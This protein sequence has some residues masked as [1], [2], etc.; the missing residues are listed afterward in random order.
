MAEDKV[1]SPLLRRMAL[2]CLFVVAVVVV[3]G[4]YTRLVDAGLGCPDWPGCYGFVLVPQAPEDLQAAQARF[5]DA[6]IEAD[7]AWPE[8]VHRY[9][10]SGLGLLILITTVVAW[11]SRHQAPRVAG[12]TLAL[13][14]MVILQGAF[15]AW[16]VTLK[17][18]PQVVTAHLLGG[19]TTLS[20]IWLLCLRLGIGRRWNLAALPGA[21]A[22]RGLAVVGL[23][24]LVL[25]IALG[26]WVSSNYAALAC[27]DFPTCQ[28]QWLPPGNLEEGFNFTQRVGPN[29]LGGKMTSEARITIQVAHRLGALLVTLALGLLVLR[30]WSV[31]RGLAAGLAVALVCQ[32]TLG[33]LNVVLVLP[34]WNATAHNAMAA[35]TLAVMITVNY[36]AWSRRTAR[37]ERLQANDSSR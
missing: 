19:F 18:W 7:K 20:L 31:H 6:P 29:Y 9:F 11:R 13:L 15:G 36:A 32:L 37:P 3:L 2:L 16:T 33:I 34:L 27:P 17:L 24:L 10:A 22:L 1:A 21:S 12:L 4:A 14:A 28:G 23:V 30:L 35:V 8:M 26:G 25:Q 5:P